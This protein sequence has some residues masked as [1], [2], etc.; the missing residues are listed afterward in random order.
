VK[1]QTLLRLVLTLSGFYA[2]LAL[3][4]AFHRHDTGTAAIYCLATGVML[5]AALSLHDSVKKPPPR[6][7]RY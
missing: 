1:P 2:N 3:I 5:A 6:P 4:Y 7:R